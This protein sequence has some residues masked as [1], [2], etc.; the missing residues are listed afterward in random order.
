VRRAVVEA[1]AKTHDAEALK[2]LVEGDASYVEAAA[3]RWEG[4]AAVNLDEKEDKLS[5]SNLFWRK[6]LVG[7]R[8]C[9]QVRSLV[10]VS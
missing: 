7:M 2:P 8:W 9:A 6:G 10:L 4:I 5:C 1:L 3:E